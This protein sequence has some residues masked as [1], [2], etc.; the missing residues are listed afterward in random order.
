M[1][2]MRGLEPKSDE[3]QRLR[4]DFIALSSYLK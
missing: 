3:E 1:N 4:S 2:S